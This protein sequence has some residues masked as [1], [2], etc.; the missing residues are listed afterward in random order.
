MTLSWTRIARWVNILAVLAI[1]GF[2]AYWLGVWTPHVVHAKNPYRIVIDVP[3]RS[4]T[5]Y[6]ENQ[7][8]LRYPVAVGTRTNRTPRG[9]FAIVQ[10][11][12]WGGGFGS[13][14][15]RFSAPWGIYGIHGTNK[16]WSVGTVA[17][18]GCIRMLNRDVEQLYATVP[19]GTPVDLIGPTPYA[20]MVRPLVPE[21]FGQDVVELQRMLRLGKWYDGPLNGVYTPA[22]TDAVTRFQK[23]HHLTGDG[24]ASLTV[25]RA[26]Q[27]ATGQA[28]LKPR[29]L[30]PAQNV[31]VR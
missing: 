8:W 9:E 15:M 1:V 31:S 21:V 7:P 6:R 22:V 23:A 18:H 27:R 2:P 3:T 19:L 4:L 5:L 11:A 12:V 25:I 28:G 13:R 16:P 10:K 20:R 26:L 24:L 17:S 29:Y 14:W 30:D